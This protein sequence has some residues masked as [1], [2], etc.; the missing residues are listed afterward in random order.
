M[1]LGLS[2]C[3]CRRVCAAGAR[4]IDSAWIA[5]PLH[6]TKNKL[7]L[8][9]IPIIIIIARC[10][11]TEASSGMIVGD[12]RPIDRSPTTTHDDNELWWLAAA[13]H[14]CARVLKFASRWSSA[15]DGS[16][17][18]W[19][20]TLDDGDDDDRRFFEV[21]KP[22]RCYCTDGHRWALR[23]QCNTPPP[24]RNNINIVA[25]ETTSTHPI[26]DI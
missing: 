9:M 15:G 23:P 7:A 10:C 13:V 8:V 19:R 22:R 12:D 26:A 1:C 21:R 17:R 24:H 4:R 2:A 5:L 6:T 16:G 18:S 11:W 3:A 20:G 25:K 14:A